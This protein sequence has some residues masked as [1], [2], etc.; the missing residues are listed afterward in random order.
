MRREAAEGQLEAEAVSVHSA[1]QV[2]PAS[3]EPRVRLYTQSCR[4]E[5]YCAQQPWTALSRSVVSLSY[6]ACRSGFPS[7]A[8]V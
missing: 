2:V 1:E 5:M 3:S 7:S 6:C 4:L 8:H